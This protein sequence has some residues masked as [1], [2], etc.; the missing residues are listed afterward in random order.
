MKIYVLGMCM[1]AAQLYG[2]QGII[3]EI[4]K[5]LGIIHESFEQTFE[6]MV[7]DPVLR[8][9]L[10]AHKLTITNR[11]TGED[12][13]LFG[14][15]DKKTKIAFSADC[16]LCITTSLDKTV[17]IWNIEKR[18]CRVLM[19][20]AQPV[21]SFM[22]SSDDRILITGCA[23]GLLVFWNLKTDKKLAI[24]TRYTQKI[25][26]IKFMGEDQFVI[27]LAS[28]AVSIWSAYSDKFEFLCDVLDAPIL[29][30][31]I[32]PGF[33]MQGTKQ[34]LESLHKHMAEKQKQDQSYQEARL[35]AKI[36]LEKLNK[37]KA[38]SSAGTD[39]EQAYFDIRYA[40]EAI[41]DVFIGDWQ[42][43]D[44][45][46][47]MG[48]VLAVNAHYINQDLR[49]AHKLQELNAFV[50]NTRA[51]F[52]YAQ[53]KEKKEAQA[54]FLAWKA[55]RSLIDDQQKAAQKLQ[56]K[57]KKYETQAKDEPAQAKPFDMLRAEVLAEELKSVHDKMKD[58][59]YWKALTG[60]GRKDLTE[61]LVNI[62]ERKFLM[63]RNCNGARQELDDLSELLDACKKNGYGE[64][65]EQA[66]AHVNKRISAVRGR[67]QLDS[68]ALDKIILDEELWQN[69]Q[70][71]KAHAAFLT[72]TTLVCELDGVQAE[73]LARTILH[74]AM[75]EVHIIGQTV[76]CA[77]RACIVNR[78]VLHKKMDKISAVIA[79]C[80]EREQ[81]VENLE[82]VAKAI[83][84]EASQ[85]FQKKYGA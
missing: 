49:L 43:S 52:E 36:A 6:R 50:Q 51:E 81:E 42:K 68:N 27:T 75:E 28:G 72:L 39:R 5:K 83:I 45:E 15:T 25:T 20:F 84:T 26:E 59:K 40:L 23:D 65:S 34:E 85:K 4:D 17:R 13:Y 61:S 29:Q 30:E 21:T 79:G 54:Q 7:A 37:L 12:D 78:V 1:L 67:L 31:E 24:S 82:Q 35:Y 44:A 63:D 77:Q 74:K 55:A 48:K 47:A 69:A 56:E 33:W 8:D 10:E 64:L 58:L 71:N 76:L 38:V 46:Q 41:K 60:A 22:L 66:R 11:V 53:E 16:Q 14:H 57:K 70:I 2:Q 80:I 3:S 73:E 32:Y 62:I 9:A 19:G 18:T